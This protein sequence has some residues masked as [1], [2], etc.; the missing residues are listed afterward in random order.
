MKPYKKE[1]IDPKRNYEALFAKYKTV[2]IVRVSIN[3]LQQCENTEDSDHQSVAVKFFVDEEAARNE[4]LMLQ[5]VYQTDKA[6]KYWEAFQC[7]SI[8]NNNLYAAVDWCHGKQIVHLDIK[9][10]NILL[11]DPA[12]APWVLSDFD[13]AR[14]IGEPVDG[15]FLVYASPEV[16]AARDK[17]HPDDIIAQSSMDIWS[18]ACVCYEIVTGDQLFPLPQDVKVLKSISERG[19]S[20]TYD[21]PRNKLDDSTVSMLEHVLK[22]NPNDRL[23]ARELQSQAN[24]GI[25]NNQ[26]EYGR[27]QKRYGR[28]RD[29]QRR[30]GNDQTQNARDV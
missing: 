9:P 24:R 16:L 5:T 17:E 25:E 19:L 6:V 21:F 15:A 14:F 18:L 12:T 30:F 23:S 10:A 3:T 8:E 22:P 20:E 11:T 29:C 1:N 26:P 7:E 28:D 13:S 27:R 4:M 2:R